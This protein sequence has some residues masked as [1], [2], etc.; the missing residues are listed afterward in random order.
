M[1]VG[2]GTTS[3]IARSVGAGDL[4]KAKAIAKQSIWVSV[5]VG[6]LFGIISYFF[7][8]PLLRVMRAEPKVLEDAIIY[9]RIVAIPSIFISLMTVFGSVL[10]AAGDTKTP[11]KVSLWIN[12]IHIGLDYLL[13]FGILG[14]TGL[15][16]EGAAWA[17]V[18]VR[19]IGTIVLYRYIQKSKVGFSVFK[20]TTLDPRKFMNPILKLATPTAIERLIMR[21][22]QVLYFGLIVQIG[23]ETYVSTYDRW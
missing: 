7:A 17:A 21:L 16:V 20:K 9:F 8:E 4:E 10:R 12:V 14:F 6:L 19:I 5:A 2:V 23:T 3:L 1:A 13:I 15:G 11:M 18:I 22:G